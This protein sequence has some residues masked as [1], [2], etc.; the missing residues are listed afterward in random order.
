MRR[1][2]K[3]ETWT[4][5][6]TTAA[7]ASF[8]LLAATLGQVATFPNLQPWYAGL[9]KPSF[10]PPNWVFGPVWTF[11]F[12]LMALAVWRILRTPKETPRRTLALTL[13]FV[14]LALNALWSWA[15]FA[16]H[17]PLLGMIDIVPQ[18]L[19]ILATI[20]VFRTIDRPAAWLMVP[21]ACWVAFATVLNVAMWRLN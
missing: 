4:L 7:D 13:F 14:Q 12:V 6:G 11:L 18:W 8:V 2:L 19:A 16:A 3:F 9:N 17:S 5:R 15:F 10:N 1:L 21:L 20:S